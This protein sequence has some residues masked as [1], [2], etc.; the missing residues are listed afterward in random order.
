MDIKPRK[1]KLSTRNLSDVLIGLRDK[2]NVIHDCYYDVASKVPTEKQIDSIAKQLPERIT[3][4][5]KQW[6]W[7]DTEVREFTYCFIRDELELD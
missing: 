7:N 2:R 3:S 5:A 6:G 1:Y 4:L